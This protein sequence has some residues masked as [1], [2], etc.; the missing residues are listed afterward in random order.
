VL[1]DIEKEQTK[2]KEDAENSEKLRWL[3]ENSNTIKLIERKFINAK[4]EVA[5]TEIKRNEVGNRK[6]SKH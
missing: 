4:D 5:A 6:K 2:I 3:K 1:E